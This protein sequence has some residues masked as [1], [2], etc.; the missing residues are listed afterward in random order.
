M[1]VSLC[2][3]SMH[4]KFELDR[5]ECSHGSCVELAL[6]HSETCGIGC[7]TF[8]AR[9]HGD[10]CV[11]HSSLVFRMS[12]QPDDAKQMIQSLQKIDPVLRFLTKATGETTI[13]RDMILKTMPTI[14]DTDLDALVDL[15]VLHHHKGRFGFPTEPNELM[16]STK[17]AAQKRL[18]TLR[19][20]LKERSKA[21]QQPN[22]SSPT[23]KRPL[24]ETAAFSDNDDTVDDQNQTSLSPKEQDDS[25]VV[26]GVHV[27]DEVVLTGEAAEAHEALMTVLKIRKAEKG[28]VDTCIPSLILPKQASY[29]GSNAAHA[30]EFTELPPSIRAMIPDTLYNAIFPNQR[31]LYSHQAKAIQAAL[32]KSHCSICTGTGSGKSLCFLLPTLTAAYNNNKTSLLLFPTKA[33][34]QDQLSKLQTLVASD[35]TLKD[36]IRPATLDGDTPQSTRKSIA[37]NSNIILTNPDTLHAALLPNWKMYQSLFASIAFVVI[38]EAHIYDGIFGAHVAMIVRRLVRL[39]RVHPVFISTSAT[40]PFP[41]HRFR[42]LVGTTDD[43]TVLTSE[44]DGSPRAA[45][46]FMVWNPPVLNLDGSSVGSVWFPRRK[47]PITNESFSSISLSGGAGPLASGS[48]LPLPVAGAPVPQFRRRHAADET[49]RLLAKA[50]ANGVRCIAFCKTRNLVE[51]VYSRTLELLKTGKDTKDLMTKVESYRG[52]YSMNERRKIEGRLFRNELIGVVGTNALELGVDVGGIDLT[53]HCGYPTSYAS[54]LQQA[55]RAGRGAGRLDQPSLSIVICFN[56]P[57]EQHMW[58]KPDILLARELSSPHSVPIRGGVIQGHLLCAGEECPVVADRSA[59]I[60]IFNGEDTTKVMPTDRELFGSTIFDEAIDELTCSNSLI[61]EE[62][63]GASVANQAVISYRPRPSFRRAWTQ[64]SIRS[65]EPISFSI[66]DVSHPQ[67]A[68][69]MDMIHSEDA[70]LDIVPYSKGM[71]IRLLNG[72]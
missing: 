38:D 25:S 8:F 15:K 29:A 1:V 55:G 31:Q 21:A 41:E 70:V 16:G 54:L 56:S 67:Q 20:Q 6:D 7:C 42:Q 12:Y 5:C 46:H 9:G 28:D 64:F 57:A 39:C 23:L 14:V 2:N 61:A 53:L 66:V 18:S 22:T 33:L 11:N 44:D 34:A 4:D 47:E 50:V 68:G 13:P 51:W 63:P 17:R 26:H 35:P 36:R 43:I 24:P 59:S 49:A 3:H 58:R 65:I 37:Q 62:L 52:G 48:D 40:L 32:S 60:L 71:P 30:S 69:K 19:K 10:R 27:P 72:I 45:K